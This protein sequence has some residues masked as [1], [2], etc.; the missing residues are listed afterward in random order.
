MTRAFR[1]KGLRS[2]NGPLS[3]RRGSRRREFSCNLRGH[4]PKMK[5]GESFLNCSIRC[6][7]SAR[8]RFKVK[9]QF[10]AGKTLTYNLKLDFASAPQ[11]VKSTC[12][13]G[14]VRTRD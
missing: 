2:R 8:A 10:P 6:D 9:S 3:A 13:A 7:K 12:K 14:T 11:L 1:W 5:R 4:F